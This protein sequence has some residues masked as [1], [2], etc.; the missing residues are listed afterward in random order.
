[1]KK[2]FLAVAVLATSLSASALTG[3]AFDPTT[4]PAANLV[5]GTLNSSIVWSPA[6]MTAASDAITL[7]T[8][9]TGSTL[10]IN[11]VTFTL[12]G[13]SGSP[14][15]VY[16]QYVRVNTAAKMN[17]TIPTVA[18]QSVTIVFGNSDAVDAAGA[19]AVTGADVSSITVLDQANGQ[20]QTV[21]LK[22]TG[23][24]I[25]LPALINKLSFISIL[26]GLP[27][28]IKETI[29]S[30]LLSKVNGELANPTNL[31]VEIYNVLGAKVL[32]S[33]APSISISSLADGVYVAKTA[34][35]TLKFV[36]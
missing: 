24:V 11:D 20:T 8:G 4:N 23:S 19:Q 6:T 12:T 22:A 9:V 3:F 2:L 32:T 15:K 25:T 31:D 28:A 34:Q 1:M 27:Q 10:T 36:K 14:L 18:G 5:A 16:P 29:S 26:P 13:T 7:T 35:G 21:T 30:K 17:L 33:K